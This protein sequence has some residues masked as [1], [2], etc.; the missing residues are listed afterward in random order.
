MPLHD[1]VG[2]RCGNRG[3][4]DGAQQWAS[5]GHGLANIQEGSIF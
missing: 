3:I 4:I 2:V 5:V 1:D